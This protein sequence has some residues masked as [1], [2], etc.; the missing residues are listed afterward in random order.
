MKLLRSNNCYVIKCRNIAA[1][2]IFI[3]WYMDVQRQQQLFVMSGAI[4][5]FLLLFFIIIIITIYLFIIVNNFFYYN[6]H[7]DIFV[8][9]VFVGCCDI[10][11]INY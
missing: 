2:S 8:V 3:I 6:K 9:V 4:K 7:I 10:V 11:M 1:T 5:N